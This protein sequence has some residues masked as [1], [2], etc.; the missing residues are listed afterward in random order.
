MFD[1]NPERKRDDALP[2]HPTGEEESAWARRVLRRLGSPACLL[3]ALLLFPLPWV[4]IRCSA[5]KPTL[6]PG[7][8]GQGVPVIY[9][10]LPV[11]DSMTTFSQTGWEAARGT[12]TVNVEA[13]DEPKRKQADE[14]ERKAIAAMH[15]SPLMATFPIVLVAGI[16][17]GLM[18]PIGRGRRWLVAGCGVVGILLIAVQM[19]VGFPLEHA[20]YKLYA[21]ELSEIAA[22][23]NKADT[24]IHIQYTPWFLMAVLALFVA[25]G[26]TGLEWWLL[27]RAREPAAAAR[28]ELAGSEGEPQPLQ[29]SP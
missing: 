5:T 1:R 9:T 29:R 19:K 13:Y 25:L 15:W 28:C 2:D 17:V 10:F 21:K 6:G 24:V 16:L 18:L 11:W 3:L 23:G 20:M 27:R 12:C 8:S 7:A 14:D 26:L 22:K 4:E